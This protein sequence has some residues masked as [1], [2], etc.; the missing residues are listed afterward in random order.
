[1]LAFTK[2]A[3]KKKGAVLLA[4]DTRGEKVY[5]IPEETYAVQTPPLKNVLDMVEAEYLLKNIFKKYGL[6]RGE[7][8]KLTNFYES[9]DSHLETDSSWKLKS[10]F[11]ALEKH[12]MH[13]LK[14]QYHDKVADL[15]P[16][17][18]GSKKA[19]V[20][21][22]GPSGAGKTSALVKILMHDSFAGRKIYIFTSQANDSSLKPLKE[23]G[24]KSVF[25]DLD[26]IPDDL[27]LCSHF[28]PDSVLFFDDILDS[29]PLSS[30]IRKCLI[31]LIST[32][33]VKG[34]HHKKKAG[35]PGCSVFCAGHKFKQG[36]ATTRIWDEADYCLLYPSSSEH[37]VR[38]FA[39]NHLGV[40]TKEMSKILKFS[41][42][43][44]FFTLKLN[45][46][47]CSIS[48]HSVLLL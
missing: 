40:H 14:V 1:M 29:L 44:R 9:L 30:P 41:Q 13:L 45:R 26:K 47:R 23:R 31:N 5:W 34:R 7:I 46:P 38:H 42:G 36:K 27:D 19:H 32:T 4:T 48:K 43:S 12:L 11:Q 39:V 18:D 17:I 28:P 3:R 10:A 16:V 33:L 15:F 37:S 2:N 20:V 6:N 24:K 35:C 25:I 21:A 8:K 22:F